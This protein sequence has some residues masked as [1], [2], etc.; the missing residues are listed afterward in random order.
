LAEMD[1]YRG[2]CPCHRRSALRVAALSAPA[3]EN[4]GIEA[5]HQ[6][7]IPQVQSHGRRQSSLLYRESSRP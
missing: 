1:C 3:T 5:D 6:R 7:R 4:L 2:T